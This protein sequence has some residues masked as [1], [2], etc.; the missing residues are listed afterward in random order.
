MPHLPRRVRGGEACGITWIRFKD[1]E[2][3]PSDIIAQYFFPIPWRDANREV[4]S[5]KIC[6]DVC[7][8]HVAGLPGIVAQSLCTVALGLFKTLPFMSLRCCCEI[9]D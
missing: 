1:T 4:K 6:F 8:L 2:S 7:R 9:A 5:V 3:S